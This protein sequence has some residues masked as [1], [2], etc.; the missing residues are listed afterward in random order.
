MLSLSKQ[1]PPHVAGAITVANWM[2]P[3]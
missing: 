1:V 3:P 2:Q